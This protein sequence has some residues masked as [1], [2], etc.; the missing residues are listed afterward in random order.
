VAAPDAS[1]GGGLW[2]L[3][4]SVGLALMCGPISWPKCNGGSSACSAVSVVVG[5]CGGLLPSS[6]SPGEDLGSS[7]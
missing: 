1:F 5:C 2:W 6:A 3:A 7:S 4:I